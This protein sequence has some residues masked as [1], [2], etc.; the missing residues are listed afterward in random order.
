MTLSNISDSGDWSTESFQ[1]VENLKVVRCEELI[2]LWQNEI[3]LEKTPIRLYGLTSLK[4]LCIENCQR[5][6][7]FQEVCFLSI[8]G[9]L[10]IKNCSVLKFLP[11]GMNVDQHV[12]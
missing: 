3:W 11:E 9:E 10:E 5:L 4:K 1:N 2:Y 8:F 12:S 7:S 6:V